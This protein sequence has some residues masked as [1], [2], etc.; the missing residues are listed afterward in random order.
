M[1]T[2][3]EMGPEEMST[4]PIRREIRVAATAERTF[5]LFTDRIGDW[6]PMSAT[7]PCSATA[8]SPARAR[9]SSS[10]P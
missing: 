5:T 7:M 10:G 4:A 9:K 1:T 2:R 3:E 8:P 6:W